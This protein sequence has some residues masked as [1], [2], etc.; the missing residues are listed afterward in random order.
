VRTYLLKSGLLE[1]ASL[2]DM[3]DLL[4]QMKGTAEK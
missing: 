2:C 3:V 1:N 4:K